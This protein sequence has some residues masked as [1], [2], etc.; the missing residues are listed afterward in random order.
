MKMYWVLKSGHN[1]TEMQYLQEEMVIEASVSAAE[2]R[3]CTN[4]LQ[5]HSLVYIYSRHIYQR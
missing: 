1:S 5:I 2:T 4:K 3:C